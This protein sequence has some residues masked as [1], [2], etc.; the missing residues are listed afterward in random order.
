MR[1]SKF[2]VLAIATLLLALGYATVVGTHN[3]IPSA[4]GASR[5]ITLRGG[6]TTGWN[7]T[8]PG[9]MI[10]VTQGDTVTLNLVSSDGAPHTFVV[11][12]AKAGIIANPDC[13]VDKCSSQFSSSTIFMFTAD[14]AAGT[15]S[16]YCSI[17]LQHMVG[18]LTV[19][20]T[21]GSGSNSGSGNPTPTTTPTTTPIASSPT[22]S[23]GMPG[24]LLILA[25][26]LLAVFAVGATIVVLARRRPKT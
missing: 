25:V 20:P 17:H 9:P 18:S 26:I 3:V 19:Q 10:I 22:Y 21:S 1:N 11:D 13:A 16:Y 7:G 5:Q 8:N 14:M 4:H 12:V 15:Y 23:S 6:F 2:A 24:T